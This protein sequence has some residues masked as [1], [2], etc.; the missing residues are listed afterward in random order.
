MQPAG[1]SKPVIYMLNVSPD[2]QD[3]RRGKH[4][5]GE[6]GH[7]LHMRVPA[8]WHDQLRWNHIIRSHI[9]QHDNARQAIGPEE[10]EACRPS[11][12]RDIEKTRPKAIFGFGNAVLKWALG[13]YGISHWTGKYAPVKIG[14][15]VCWFFPL[16]H[17]KDIINSRRKYIPKHANEYGSDLEFSFALDLRKAF[18]TVEKLPEAAIH[19]AEDVFADVETVPYFDDNACARITAFLQRATAASIAGFDYETNALRP[20]NDDTRILTAAVSIKGETLAF[21][22]RHS[23]A[24]WSPENLALVEKALQTFLCKHEGRIVAHNLAFEMEWSAVKFGRHSIRSGKWGCSQSQAFLL[25]ERQNVG[26]GT[27]PLAL[28]TLTLQH[29]GIDL[30]SQSPIDRLNLDAADLDAVL[31]YNGGDARY[32]RLVYGR[33]APMIEEQGLTEVYRHHI[34]RVRAIVLTQIKG[35]PISQNV[36]QGLF[37]KYYEARKAADRAI[38]R[39][40]IGIRFK[41]DNGEAFRPSAEKDIKY[42]LLNL[43]PRRLVE[44]LLDENGKVPQTDE[45]TLAKLKHPI[46]DQI[47]KW[48]KPN[49]VLSTYIEPVMDACIIDGVEMPRSPH[50]F[51]DGLLHPVTNTTRVRTWR[52]SSD[53]PNYQNWPTRDGERKEV[54]KQVKPGPGLKVVSFDFAGIQA[55]NVAMESKDK[56]LIKAFWDRYDIHSDW[57]ERIVRRFPKWVKEGSKQLATDKALFKAYRNRAKNEFVFPSFFGAHPSS[58]SRYLGIDQ[59]ITEALHGEFWAMFPDIKGWHKHIQTFFKKNGYV[60]GLSGFK[61]R[62]PISQNELINA[63][64]QADEAIIVCDA[65]IRLSERAEWALQPNMEIHDDLTFIWPTKKV[66]EYA[67]IVLQAML[68]PRFKWAQIVPIGVEMS[69]GDDWFVKQTVGEFFS[70]KWDGHTIRQEAHK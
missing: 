67:E 51:D 70:D 62:A 29:F 69:V 35:I 60:T 1:S 33:Q 36:T 61:R 30:K 5:S 25:D 23:Q 43:L 18:E 40:E 66:D 10:I 3:F 8:R 59:R 50:V 24:Q 48:R 55:R 41:Q 12:I 39:S 68:Y 20:Y 7:A 32:H 42:V 19:S 15:H 6:I 63:P 9:P 44:P 17:P 22:L 11:I 26:A 37:Q 27:G 52:T 4:F 45:K 64:I 53:N 58:L 14:N 16:T 54:R 57:C 34:R 56:A 31:K 13:V 49:K 46:A 65:M 2:K 21:P 47:I 28:T 38:K